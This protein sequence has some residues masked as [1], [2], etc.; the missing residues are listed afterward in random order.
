MSAFLKFFD[1]APGWVYALV[2]AGLLLAVGGQQVRVA[3]AHTEIATLKLAAEK[4]RGDRLQL[5]AAHNLK[6][7]GM[8]AMHA[9]QQQEIIS[10]YTDFVIRLQG[11]R[12][13]AVDRADRVQRAAE[14][15]TTRGRSISADDT[16]AVQRL[17]DD[18]AVL[19]TLVA[20]GFRLVDEGRNLLRERDAQVGTLKSIIENDRTAI[21][22]GSDK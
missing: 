9:K 1:I 17:V 14:D 12:R 21:C 22:G 3:N 11:E 5:V 15:R 18:N 16:S 8:Q 10:G 7:A 20:E 2:I 13:L 19:N 6:V 4:D